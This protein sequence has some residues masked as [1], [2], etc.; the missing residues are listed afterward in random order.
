MKNSTIFLV[1]CGGKG[2][3]LWPVSGGKPKQFLTIGSGQTMLERCIESIKPLDGRLGLV[4]G[5][6]H[7][8]TAKTITA[9]NIDHFFVEP[10]SKNTAPAIA[11][12]TL[13][14]ISLGFEN[15][16]V[17]FLPCDQQISGLQDFQASLL[18]AINLT[19]YGKLVLIGTK[20]QS[21]DPELGYFKT[22]PNGVVKSFVEKPNQTQAEQ[23]LNKNF[24]AN[25]GIFIGQVKIFARNLATFCPQ[26]TSGIKR[27]L[28]TGSGFDDLPSISFDSAILKPGA[29]SLFVEGTFQF[30]D[31]GKVDNFLKFKQKEN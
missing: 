1:L 13:K 8:E 24:L 16:S 18:K 6:S 19:K 20:P 2:K 22:G 26:I 28:A 9:N 29:E 12:A 21:A 3:R 14:L 30:C 10:I 7:L 15:S 25:T 4:L 27:F 23:L 31:L 5:K 17:V 11:L